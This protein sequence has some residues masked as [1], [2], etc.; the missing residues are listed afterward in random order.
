TGPV[1]TDRQ[2]VPVVLADALGNRA[3]WDDDPCAIPKACKNE[4][5]IDGAAAA[6]LRDGAAL[7]EL[8]AWLD[9]QAPGTVTETGVVTRLEA[10]RRVDNALQD[11][12]FETIAGTGPHGAI[13][14]YRV[15]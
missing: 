14:H 13:M 9:T 7:C 15:T 12:S 5:E 10:A 11:I 3:V 6:H 1:R 2:S 4:A 8:L